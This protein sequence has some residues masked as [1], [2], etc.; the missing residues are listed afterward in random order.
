MGGKKKT[1]GGKPQVDRSAAARKAAA[2][3]K[4]N[5]AKAAKN[6]PDDA[7]QAEAEAVQ[8]GAAA[9]HPSPGNLR[10]ET[11]RR[12]EERVSDA[13]RE[14]QRQDELAEERK[15]HAKRT[16]GSGPR[17]GWKH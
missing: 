11:A 8:R 14:K 4:R 10:K 6:A 17:K 13:E 16:D 12:A 5:A 3:R 9:D 7:Q 2:T 15:V 1:S